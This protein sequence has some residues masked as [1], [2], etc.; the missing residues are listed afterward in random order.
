MQ[1]LS[2]GVTTKDPDS[3]LVPQG[4]GDIASSDQ[5][6]YV[7][8]SSHSCKAWHKGQYRDLQ[9]VL[10][11]AGK[12]FGCQASGT[13]EFHLYHNGRDVGVV[14]AGLPSDQPLWGFVTIGVRWKVEA[15]Y[16][17]PKGET[18]WCDVLCCVMFVSCQSLHLYMLV[19]FLVHCTSHGCCVIAPY[20]L[21]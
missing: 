19:S 11:S 2:I 15:N 6:W 7:F 13:G 10:D 20:I 12:T 17:I 18:V 21:V 1:A 14:L 4:F 16:V 8:I 5:Y 9:W 3:G